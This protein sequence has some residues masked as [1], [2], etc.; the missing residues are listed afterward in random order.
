MTALSQSQMQS[1]NGEGFF[2]GFI[3]GASVGAL[4]WA[5]TSPDPVSKLALGTLWTTAIGSCGIALA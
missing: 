4:V 1:I 2:D 5:V 3:C